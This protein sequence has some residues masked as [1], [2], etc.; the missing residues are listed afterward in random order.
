L[1][2]SGGFALSG[3]AFA[4]GNLLLAR[5]MPTDDFGRFSLGLALFIVFSHM[6]PFGIN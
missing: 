3:A 2:A 1:I 6:A 5:T 4:V